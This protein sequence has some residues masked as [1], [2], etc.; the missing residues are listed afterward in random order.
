MAGLD[1]SVVELL[2]INV[3]FAFSLLST[4]VPIFAREQTSF[5]QGIEYFV[6]V[7]GT[8]ILGCILYCGFVRFKLSQY[9]SV[10][11]VMWGVLLSLYCGRY[12]SAYGGRVYDP[13]GRYV[14][15]VGFPYTLFVVSYL[16]THQINSKHR[17]PL[18]AFLIC[19]SFFIVFYGIQS[20]ALTIAFLLSLSILAI[21]Y[22]AGIRLRHVVSLFVALVSISAIT[23][24][25]I[26]DDRIQRY[27]SIMSIMSIMSML[28]GTFSSI[29]SVDDLNAS[30]GSSKT[31]TSGFLEGEINYS[32]VEADLSYLAR[33]VDGKT[34]NLQD[35]SLQ[36]RYKML[37]LGAEYVKD[38]ALFG[39]GNMAEKELLSKYFTQSHP[40][41]H[42]QYLSYLVVG[43]I[44]H[45]IFGIAFSFGILI[46]AIRNVSH[47]KVI[48]IAPIFIFIAFLLFVGSHNQQLGFQNLYIYYSFILLGML[49]L[50]DEKLRV[51]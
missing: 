29:A 17:T 11:L 47:I 1:R 32:N 42:N 40:H 10:I 33:A 51:T 31:K 3:I 43:G 48:Q 12:L 6:S 16:A 14:F 34:V 26:S 2:C 13:L 19:S 38:H 8:S 44:I 9:L 22:I 5:G 7:V 36:L 23:F 37:I 25:L 27:S 30:P 15:D 50:H 46:V 4:A 35:G 39:H 28:S 24:Q 21:R 41:L 45:L 20:R 49:N 18:T